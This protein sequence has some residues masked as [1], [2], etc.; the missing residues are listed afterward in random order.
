MLAEER[1]RRLGLRA[2]CPSSYILFAPG[3][4]R[5]AGKANTS[6]TSYKCML[7]TS[8]GAIFVRIKSPLEMCA[9]GGEQYVAVLVYQQKPK[10]GGFRVVTG[11]SGFISIA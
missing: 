1:H 8:L 4:A 2:F 9:G 7:A 5:Q 3:P 10:T 11:F 6:K